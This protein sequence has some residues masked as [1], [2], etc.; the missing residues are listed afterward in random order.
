MSKTRA[1]IVALALDEMGVVGAG[2][3]A[4]AEDADKVDALFDG[5]VAELAA[6]GVYE[7][8]DEST[9]PDEATNSLKILLAIESAS[10][11][12][13]QPDYGKREDA[14]NR[15]RVITQRVDPPSRYLKADTALRPKQTFSLARWT[16]GG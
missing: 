13:M 8:D 6:R 14:E 7:L 11:F 5:L 15:L 3:T 12:G 16:R 4:E 9:I 1:E 10:T 2:Q